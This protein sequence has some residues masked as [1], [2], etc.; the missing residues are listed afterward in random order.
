[1]EIKIKDILEPKIRQLLSRELPPAIG[2]V[3]E[4]VKGMKKT[5]Y[6]SDRGFHSME[7]YNKALDEVINK[8]KKPI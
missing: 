6:Y 7:G 4:M 8:L 3:I 1:M 2:V 5:E